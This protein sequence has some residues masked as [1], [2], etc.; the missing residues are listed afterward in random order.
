MICIEK[1]DAGGVSFFLRANGGRFV[2]RDL[3]VPPF[4]VGYSERLR[5]LRV[6]WGLVVGEGLCSSLFP[7]FAGVRAE[8]SPAP[9]NGCRGR[10]PCNRGW[11][12]AATGLAGHI[13]PALRS[14]GLFLR[15]AGPAC[16]AF[17]GGVIGTVLLVG[18]GLGF[19]CRGGR[20]CPPRP[21]YDNAK[22]ADSASDTPRG[23]SGLWSQC[24]WGK[25]SAPTEG[26]RWRVPFIRGWWGA[27]PG[28]GG[29]HRSRLSTRGNR[30]GFVGWG[31]VG[32]WL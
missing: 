27:I 18:G 5:W 26:C 10:V 20:L 4:N 24:P 9:T 31:W 6:G 21:G 14:E 13:G 22:G 15:R 32:V 29:T 2:G 7:Y 28:F 30:N 8:Q 3:R 11:R 19:G 17:R 1:G 23:T 12:W 16:P 25:S